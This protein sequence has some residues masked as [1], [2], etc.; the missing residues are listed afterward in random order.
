MA[1][2]VALP[3]SVDF[4]ELISSPDPEYNWLIPGLL[5]RGDRV[6]FTGNE[7]KGKSTLLRQIAVQSAA[8]LHPFTLEPITPVKVLFIDLENGKGQVQ[9]EFKKLSQLDLIPH[10][11]EVARW[12][13]GLNL[14]EDSVRLAFSNFLAAL[15]PD[16]LILG[17]M[18]KLA[19]HLDR[20]EESS[21]VA[22]FLDVCR[23][24]YD[25]TL[26]MES[27]QPHAVFT[28]EGRLRPERPFGSS[29]WMRWPEFGF[30]LE[31]SGTLRP[32]R[33][34][35][36]ADRQWPVKLKRD[37]FWPWTLDEQTCGICGL[38]LS[39]SQSKYCSEKCA[40]AGRQRDFRAKK[41]NDS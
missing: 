23:G 11:L 17:P 32:W 39:G 30:C 36:D 13:S 5:E 35:R 8:G 33:G 34:A 19:A 31:D 9:R 29:L 6:I 24:T 1:T 37:G 40:S 10:Q 12:P 3:A 41:R 22:A 28:N 26:L 14:G 27:H 20:E 38:E 18:Y 4:N 25:F 2:D 16:L 15:R 21:L 7:G